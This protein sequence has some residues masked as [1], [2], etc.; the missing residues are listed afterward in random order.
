MGSPIFLHLFLPNVS[1]SHSFFRLGSITVELLPIRLRRFLLC[2]VVV[3]IFVGFWWGGARGRGRRNAL[4]FPVCG[5]VIWVI[6]AVNNAHIVQQFVPQLAKLKP[7]DAR[8]AIND[9]INEA[10]FA[11]EQAKEQ[12]GQVWTIW[13][14]NGLHNG[15]GFLKTFHRIA[16]IGGVGMIAQGNIANEPLII[17][18]QWP[19]TSLLRATFDAFT[20]KIIEFFEILTHIFRWDQRVN[21]S[22]E[23]LI[24]LVNG[25]N[26]ANYHLVPY[27]DPLRVGNA[28]MI[29][30][31]P[32]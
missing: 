16:I 7:L 17:F 10:E 3:V 21:V 12:I 31:G 4:Q 26:G 18:G 23:N 19:Q 13:A 22:D 14:E 1:Q 24:A 9:Q 25:L 6:L 5:N 8:S 29:E 27:E 28:A 32:E 30:N 15:D 11:Y 20:F 2:T